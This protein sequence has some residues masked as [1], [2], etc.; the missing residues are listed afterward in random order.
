MIQKEVTQCEP[1]IECGRFGA[2]FVYWLNTV[3]SITL[4]FTFTKFTFYTL[5]NIIIVCSRVAII[6]S[7]NTCDISKPETY[8]LNIIASQLL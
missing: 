2:H 8:Y 7:Q 3:G 6:D 4:T 5:N 1:S